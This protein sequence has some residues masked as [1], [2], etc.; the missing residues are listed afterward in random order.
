MYSQ[1]EEDMYLSSRFQLLRQAAEGRVGSGRNDG[2]RGRERLYHASLSLKKEAGRG[3]VHSED[4]RDMKT[5]DIAL[6][7]QYVTQVPFEN[8]FEDCRKD[9]EFKHLK[10]WWTATCRFF[11]R[12]YP[13]IG[14]TLGRDHSTCVFYYKRHLKMMD[15]EQWYREGYFKMLDELLTRLGA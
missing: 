7:F 4:H 9:N 13:Q 14:E 2:S 6:A 8:L 12:S 1:G 10:Y 3:S 15:D 5:L 11:K